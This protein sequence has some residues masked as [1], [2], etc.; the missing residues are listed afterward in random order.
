MV[1]YPPPTQSEKIF[2]VLN[3]E[4]TMIEDTITQAVWDAFVVA[5]FVATMFGAIVITTVNLFRKVF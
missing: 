3:E 1:V 4:P 2:L 5:T